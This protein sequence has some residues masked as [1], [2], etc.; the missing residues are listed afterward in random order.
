MWRHV[1]T[2]MV[3]LPLIGVGAASAAGV[4]PSATGGSHLTAH[5][6]FGPNTL[7]LQDFGFNAKLKSDGSADGWFT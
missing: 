4:G 1:V 6:V 5:D 3:V 2:I 7:V